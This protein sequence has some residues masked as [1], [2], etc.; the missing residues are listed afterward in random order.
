MAINESMPYVVVVMTQSDIFILKKENVF[1]INVFNRASGARG[2]ELN[3]RLCHTKDIKMWY[4]ML[5]C[6]MLSI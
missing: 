4:Q 3:P 6:L 2:R 5:P 1:F